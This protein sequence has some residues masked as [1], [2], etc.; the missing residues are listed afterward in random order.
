MGGARGLWP[1]FFGTEEEEELETEWHRAWGGGLSGIQTQAQKG[2]NK[3]EPRKGE[4]MADN[5]EGVGTLGDHG[6]KGKREESKE[7]RA[8]S[9]GRVLRTRE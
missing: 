4:R 2:Q 8:V 7:D 5:S 6:R 3:T 1:A 9:R